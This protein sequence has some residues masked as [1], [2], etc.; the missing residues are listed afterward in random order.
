MLYTADYFEGLGIHDVSDPINPSQVSS[1]ALPGKAIAVAV[2]DHIAY[3]VCGHSSSFQVVDCANS[4]SPQ[5]LASL[6]TAGFGRRVV[7]DGDYAYICVNYGGLQVVDVSDPSAPSIVAH[8]DPGA[9]AVLGVALGGDSVFLANDHGGITILDRSA[10]PDLQYVTQLSL[11]PDIEKAW[12]VAVRGQH[13]LVAGLGGVLVADISDPISPQI[14]HYFEAHYPVDLE[15]IDSF[16]LFGDG[17]GQFT[18]LDIDDP[19][20][21]Q[22]V[23]SVPTT[24]ATENGFLTVHDDIAFLKRN[25]PGGVDVFSLGCIVDSEPS[26]STIHVPEDYPSIQAGINAASAGDTVLI[27]AGTYHEFNIQMKSNLTVRGDSA[28][29]EDVVITADQQGHVFVCNGIEGLALAN[30][31]IRDG[32]AAQGGGVYAYRSSIEM[33]KLMFLNCVASGGDGGGAIW[34]WHQ[35]GDPAV[36]SISQTTFMG[37]SAPGSYYGGG[38]ILA[39]GNRSTMNLE[40]EGCTFTL[41]TSGANGGAIYSGSYSSSYGQHD[42]FMNVSILGCVFDANSAIQNGGGV[43]L[44]AVSSTSYGPSE[45]DAM[46]DQSLFSGNQANQNGGAICI[47]SRSANSDDSRATGMISSCTLYANSAE[48]LGGGVYCRAELSSNPCL[49]DIQDSIISHGPAGHGIAQ[50]GASQV[51]VTCSNVF[52][53]LAANY[54]GMPNQTGIG[55]NISA[56]PMYCDSG[57]GDFMVVLDSPCAPG[58]NSCGVLIGAFPVGCEAV[59]V[60]LSNFHIA[61]GDSK[62]EFTWRTPP[63]SAPP[64]FRLQGSGN[65]HLWDV[66]HSEVSPGSFTAEDYSP[67]LADGGDF[68]YSLHSREDHAPWQL[69]RRESISLEPAAPS[70]RI[71]GVWPNPS[72]PQATITYQLTQSSQMSITVFDIEGRL[73]TELFNAHVDRGRHEATWN[74]MDYSGR[75]VASGVYLVKLEAGGLSESEKVILVR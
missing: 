64:Q 61:T 23:T 60:S 43:C 17:A 54:V 65:G 41:N 51:T 46:I 13:L 39:V 21:P 52:N 44:Q 57:L 33:D 31:T 25:L 11:S 38:A 5:L 49:I 45:L 66:H 3:I 56:D 42:A 4:A 7:L 15:V 58:G 29:P 6:P 26:T 50:D 28:S 37:N 47:H 19:V 73:V 74:G 10:F 69:V 59:P 2:R 12:D 68:T 22:V 72:N 40:C 62:V 14:V 9:E 1:L 63:H 32:Y 48:S 16:V 34:A 24:G 18:I 30:M 20:S 35:D 71:L 27:G 70:A 55:G 53:N 67:F 8:F 75:P 36:L